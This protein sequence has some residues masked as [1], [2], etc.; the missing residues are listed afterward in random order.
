MLDPMTH[1]FDAL[2]RRVLVRLL[3]RLIGLA[4][5][6]GRAED[7]LQDALEAG[8]KAWGQG[9]WPHN[10]EAWLWTVARRR[11]LDGLRQ[12]GL[13]G[14][15]AWDA[16]RDESMEGQ[17]MV[18]MEEGLGGEDDSLRLI[19]T[20]CHP[21]LAPE[22]QVAL[23]LNSLCGL[24]AAEIGAAF[25][26][27]KLSMAQRLVRVKSKIRAAGIPFRVPP[28]VLLGERLPGVLR[29]FYLVFTTRRTV[30]RSAALDPHVARVHARRA[31][32]EGAPGVDAVAAW[33]RGCAC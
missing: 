2:S 27:S 4:R 12:R 11:L 7:A 3:P 14:S 29:V 21:A 28:E 18:S 13:V 30:R 24:T 10:P 22:A 6:F 19:F 15:E 17:P 25:L 16:A 32:V 26:V 8:W 1:A 23:T 31:R 33:P 5:D 20:C 9:S